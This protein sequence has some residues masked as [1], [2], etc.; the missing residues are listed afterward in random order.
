MNEQGTPSEASAPDCPLLCQL[1]PQA[2][3]KDSLEELIEM[4]Y[5]QYLA[6]RELQ[7]LLENGILQNLED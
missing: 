3:P 7:E 1:S 5:Q 6:Q 2:P 4:R